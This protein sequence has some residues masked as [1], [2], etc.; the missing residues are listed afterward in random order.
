ME[1]FLY[2]SPA[3]KRYLRENPHEQGEVKFLQSI[4]E[5]NMNVVDVG[6]YIGITTVTMAKKVSKV[7][8]FEPVPE[9]FGILK[10]N[11]ASNGLKNVNIHRLAVSNREG[12]TEFYKEGASSSII[13][14]EDANK[15]LVSVTAIDTF[16]AQE[17]IDRV[18]LI[19]MD[20]EGSEL[21]VLKGA[22]KTLRENKVKI[23]CEIHHDYLEELGQSVK[24]V[25][26]YLK[27]LG[28]KVYGVSLDDLRLKEEID[29]PEYIYAVN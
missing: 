17:K 29:K 6:S 18:D 28:F 20:C 10:K 2:D 11:I 1:Y 23:F 14:R 3:L 21:L 25:E 27:K 12:T 13:F 19:N 24:D 15:I 5:K 4:T 16:V 22:E 8:A 7:Y 9:Y 26:E